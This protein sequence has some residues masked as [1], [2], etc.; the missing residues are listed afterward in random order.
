V[1][2][3]ASA[4][5]VLTSWTAG[6]EYA[7]AKLK[8]LR[9]AGTSTYSVIAADGPHP[10]PLDFNTYPIRVPVRQG[11]AIGA[12]V[13]GLGRC[14][15]A[16]AGT[17]VASFAG[18]PAPGGSVTF[19]TLNA[20]TVPV[21]ATLEP[22]VDGDGYGDETQDA[23]PADPTKQ[24]CPP[25]ATAPE[26]SIT[27]GPKRKTKSKRVTFVFSSSEPGS[28]FECSVDGA[29]FKPCTSPM[30]VRVKPGKHNFLVRAR[31]AAGNL[32]SSEAGAS[33]KL[34]KKKKRPKN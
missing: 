29:A 8:V 16:L 12:F 5:G 20:G 27:K 6:R 15:A 3:V 2:Y 13:S 7:P 33:W 4:D 18:D 31:D 25:D 9:P 24:S 30:K 19:D 10:T 11:D 22:D 23:C 17:S 1:N 28:T 21:R 14:V 26:T 32:D 34:I